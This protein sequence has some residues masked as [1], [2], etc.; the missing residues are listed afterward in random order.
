MGPVVMGQRNLVGL[1]SSRLVI[2]W[3]FLKK[4][5]M[6]LFD[7]F[8]RVVKSCQKHLSIIWIA[9]DIDRYSALE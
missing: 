3:W 1:I 7:V 6:V 2:S 8:Q 5:A 9:K 4:T